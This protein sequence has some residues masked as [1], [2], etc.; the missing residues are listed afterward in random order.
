VKDKM[1]VIAATPETPLLAWRS[2]TARR[3][4]ETLS[5]SGK[6]DKTGQK[7]DNEIRQIVGFGEH[8]RNEHRRK[9]NGK[10]RLGR[11]LT[12]LEAERTGRQLN[13][14]GSSVMSILGGWPE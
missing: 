3:G 4:L 5:E 7:S 6:S 1:P 8:A 10:G 2:R 12:G 11:I 9:V 13:F 14:L